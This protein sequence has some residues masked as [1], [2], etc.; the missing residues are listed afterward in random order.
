MDRQE[1]V[2]RVATVH[3]PAQAPEEA[4]QSRGARGLR[5]YADTVGSSRS[6]KRHGTSWARETPTRG[7]AAIAAAGTGVAAHRVEPSAEQVEAVCVRARCR[8]PG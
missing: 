4:T 2:C 7:P 5:R 1:T 3:T 8:A 6:Q